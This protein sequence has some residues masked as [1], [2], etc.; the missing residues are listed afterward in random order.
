MSLRSFWATYYFVR[1]LPQANK[2]KEAW[3]SGSAAEGLPTMCEVLSSVP[4]TGNMSQAQ[5]D[6]LSLGVHLN[7]VQQTFA[8]LPVPGTI[9]GAKG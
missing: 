2:S 7:F 3:V 9:S 8:D 1:T 6:E 5:D 4:S